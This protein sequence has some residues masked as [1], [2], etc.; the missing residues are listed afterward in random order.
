MNHITYLLD[1]QA[2]RT[3]LA[4]WRTSTFF[5]VMGCCSLAVLLTGVPQRLFV[6][7][8]VAL[9]SINGSIMD[10][11]DNLQLMKKIEEDSNVL[12][13]IVRINSPGGT[14]AGA[15]RLY[16]GLRSLGEKKPV[17][18]IIETLAASGGYIAAL[19]A[20]YIVAQETSLVGSIGVLF[21]TPNFEEALKKLGIHVDVVKS[22]LLKAT[23]NPLVKNPPESERMLEGLVSD[24]YGWFK[25][26]VVE[27]RGLSHSQLS[28]A[29][30]GAVF[31]GQKALDLKLIDRLGSQRQAQEWLEK[32]HGI[33]QKTFVRPY[34]TERASSWGFLKTLFQKARIL[35]ISNSVSEILE[36]QIRDE[37]VSLGVMETGVLALWPGYL[38]PSQ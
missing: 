1:R 26:L 31:T 8:H 16:H 23:P 27:R 19:G 37:F 29:A 13:T 32:S 34:T 22:T 36:S 6:R 14:A 15:E 5:A 18:A 25:N 2:L 28:V 7:K 3:A 17:V 12:G 9:I 33:D 10:P 21:Q 35:S 38:T 4:R 11:T 24:M 30:N 20:D